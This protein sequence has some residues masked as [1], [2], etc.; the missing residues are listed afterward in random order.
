MN[1]PTASALRPP[2]SDTDFYESAIAFGRF[3]EMLREFPAETLH[4]TIPL[5]HNTTNRYRIF[6]KALQDDLAG[7]AAGVRTISASRSTASRRR[8]RSAA[9]STAVSC[10]L[11]VTHNDT[12]LNNVLFDRR[13]RKALCVLDLDTV[14]PGS[15]LYDYGDS[16]RFGAATAAEDEKDLSK[17]GINLHLF[18]V[19]TAGYL[20]ACKSL[21]PKELELLPLG[22]KIITL[23]LAVRFLTDY[24]DG[25]RYFRVAYPE[26][27]LGARPR[28]DEAGGRHGGPLG[29][30]AGHRRRRSG[31]AKLRRS[32]AV[33]R[34]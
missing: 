29:R 19:Y 32:Y 18:Q 8:A 20:A 26:H 34:R 16:I 6:R 5:F 9:C 24:L 28:A 4:E 22:A 11:R 25:D 27:N 30:D 1:L 7:R 31:K 13:T 2:E 14:M 15:S 33:F 10:P 17:M 3:Q 21:T 12:K 23:E